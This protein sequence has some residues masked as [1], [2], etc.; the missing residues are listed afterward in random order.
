MSQV[1]PAYNDMIAPMRA[2]HARILATLADH[3][4]A[5]PPATDLA[6]RAHA[7]GSGAARAYPMQ[8]IL[9]YHGMTDWQQRIAYLPSI[10]VTNDAGHTLTLVEFD[11]AL[12]ADEAFI[13]GQRAH[14]REHDRVVQS[15]DAVRALAGVTTRARVISRNVV[16]A[17][18]TGKGLGS[19]ASASAAL[20][21]A[22]VE[23]LFGSTGSQDLRL[24]STLA[25]LLAGSGCRSA[26]GGIG[27]W[28]S[29]PGIAAHESYALRIDPPGALDDL[30]LVTV[31]I[32]ARIGLKTEEAH[33]DAP[34]S[35][36]FRSWMQSR[37]D[38]IMLC[39]AAAR[40]GDWQTLGRWAEID[41]MRLH[42][43]TMS[44]GDAYKIYGWEPENI[45]LFRLC[46][47]LRAE[48][49]P[50][51][52]ST[53]T[54]PTAVFLVGTAHEEQLVERIAALDLG[55]EIIRGRL[56]GPATVVDV[57]AARRAL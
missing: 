54:G 25:R 37:A 43:I 6:G 42:G 52:C 14:G 28:L 23:A 11:R 56:G 8:G 26:V 36:L 29:Y 20:A 44:G 3:D 22:A 21:L 40:S 48:G 39:I 50:V 49:V 55:V 30:R 17:S 57:A 38:E 47:T 10:S 4:I 41:S 53:D 13:G 51:Y 45:T 27:L 2:D 5:L 24:V 34:A 1:P 33:R 18:T 9:K 15:L 32:D 12:A 7:T 31:P 16:R 35:T 19:S 46:N